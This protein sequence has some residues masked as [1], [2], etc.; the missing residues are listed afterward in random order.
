MRVT[1]GPWPG[2]SPASRWTSTSWSTSVADVA[3]RLLGLSRDW[4]SV[5]WP[6]VYLPATGAVFLLFIAVA[7]HAS[8]E[9]RR[10]LLVGLGLLVAAMLAEVVSA[11]FSTDETAAGLVHALEGAVEEACELGGWGLLTVATLRLA[12]GARE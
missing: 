7:R 10:R 5:I 12:V 2:C 6:I 1:P 9:G 8:D 3:L 11:P 4:D